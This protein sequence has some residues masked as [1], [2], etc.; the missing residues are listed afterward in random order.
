MNQH[1]DRE[2]AQ[3]IA[4]LSL[5]SYGST[6]AWNASGTTGKPGSRILHVA[7]LGEVAHEHYRDQYNSAA[8]DHARDEIIT[9]ARRHLHREIRQAERKAGEDDAAARK[10]C[11][12][13][14]EG[15][16]AQD[17]AGH[18]R[19]TTRW[20]IQARKL[21]DRDANTGHRQAAALVRVEE[22][23]IRAIELQ[24]QGGTVRS[25]AMRLGVSKSNIHRA[26]RR[27]A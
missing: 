26:L 13:D 24:E 21:E 19:R 12:K 3:I 18:M 15:W 20:V 23:E 17:A 9:D 5:L 27:A 7:M 4:H 22:W 6:T 11:I 8:T 14:C 25:I 10:R 2:M 16:P 1:Q